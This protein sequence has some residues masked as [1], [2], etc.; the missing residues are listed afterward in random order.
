MVFF[1]E[2]AIDVVAEWLEGRSPGS[3]NSAFESQ[4]RHFIFRGKC[5]SSVCGKNSLDSKSHRII[6]TDTPENTHRYTG[7]YPQIHRKIPADTPDKNTGIFT[8]ICRGTASH[9]VYLTENSSKLK[10]V[11]CHGIFCLRFY[12]PFDIF[13][14]FPSTP[15]FLTSISNKDSALVGVKSDSG[16]CCPVRTFPAFLSK[17]QRGVSA[18]ALTNTANNSNKMKLFSKLY[19]PVTP[20]L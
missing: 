10:T 20:G 14:K 7:K 15:I 5:M 1:H 16:Q 19:Q 3:D 9:N 12:H 2:K 17:L 6:P 4:R 11:Q 8:S 18:S 13:D